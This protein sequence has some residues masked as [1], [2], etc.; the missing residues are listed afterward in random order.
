VSKAASDHLF[1]DWQEARAVLK[2]FDERLHDLRKY[3]FTLI[4]ALLAIQGLLLPFVPLGPIAPTT[5]LTTEKGPDGAITK[6]TN[7]TTLD[8]TKRE[9]SVTNNGLPYPVKIAILAATAILVIALRWLD[10]HYQG[11]QRGAALRAKVVERFLNLEVTEEISLRYR[12]EKLQARIN[13]LYYAFEVAIA[14]LAVFLLPVFVLKDVPPSDLALDLGLVALLSGSMLVEA[15]WYSK[16][17]SPRNLRSLSKTEWAIDRTTCTK[18]DQVRIMM[19][20]ILE[21]DSPAGGVRNL[22]KGRILWDILDSDQKSIFQIDSHPSKLAKAVTV[23]PGNSY[24]WIW[25]VEQK[26]GIYHVQVD[27]DDEGEKLL[28]VQMTDFKKEYRQD[29]HMM[30]THNDE[31]PDTT[32]RG[33]QLD[34]RIQILA[35]EDAAHDDSTEK[36]PEYLS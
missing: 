18:G 31:Q 12:I 36:P 27:L 17:L 34:R 19:T 28:A 24:V 23:P 22:P 10:G 8:P 7:A 6:F 20:N 35:K 14:V 21:P 3:G 29:G 32:N 9:N 30:R 4:T 25:R 11:I 2:N 5:V 1:E 15:Y 16:A 33:R 13:H 26:P